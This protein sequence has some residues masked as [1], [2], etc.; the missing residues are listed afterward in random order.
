MDFYAY[1]AQARRQSRAFVGMFMVAVAAVV[2]A[3]DAVIFTVLAGRQAYVAGRM[4]R[5]L[6]ATASSPLEGISK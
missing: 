3:L 4:P 2:I 1:Q 6:Y 5:K